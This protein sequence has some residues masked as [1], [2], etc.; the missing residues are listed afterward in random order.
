MEA[1]KLIC[2]AI[3]TEPLQDKWLKFY[4]KEHKGKTHKGH[5]AEEANGC[6][7]NFVKTFVVKVFGIADG[8]KTHYYWDTASHPCRRLTAG[9]DSVANEG[10][11]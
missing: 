4:H 1:A 6:F 5:K 8:L 2:C 7:V 3:K 11:K 9:G 10:I